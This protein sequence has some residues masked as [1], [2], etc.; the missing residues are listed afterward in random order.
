MEN[1][2]PSHGFIT[3]FAEVTPS[4][5]GSEMAQ[6]AYEAWGRA[7]ESI[8]NA[9]T[10]ETEPANLQPKVRL[11]NRQVAEFL[12]N[13]P[14]DIDQNRLKN[15][16]ESIEAPWSQREEKQ[17]RIVWNKEFENS[18]A[19]ALYVIEEIERIGAEPFHAPETLPPIDKED[20]LLVCWISIVQ[21]DNEEKRPTT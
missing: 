21:E 4:F 16:L 7:R 17:L 2:R 14:P 8:F 19:R 6:R 10:Y 20:I 18:E 15:C 5:N 12:R 11:L 13:H 1:D 9:W 3:L